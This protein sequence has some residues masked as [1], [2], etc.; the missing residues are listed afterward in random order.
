M[1]NRRTKRL[2]ASG[3][4]DPP[5]EKGRSLPEWAAAAAV[6]AGGALALA[7]IDG[8]EKPLR[9]IAQDVAL[10]AEGQGQ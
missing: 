6:L 5:A 4:E 10:P 9:P 1:A 2:S 8:G 7:W 3:L